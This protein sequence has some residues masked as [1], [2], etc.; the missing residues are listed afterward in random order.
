[1]LNLVIKN[2][3]HKYLVDV[4]SL[5]YEL[6]TSSFKIEGVYIKFLEKLNK[7]FALNSINKKV[8]IRLEANI[9]IL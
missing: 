7:T 8:I 2:H 4:I 9:I 5:I 3:E 6:K 1:M